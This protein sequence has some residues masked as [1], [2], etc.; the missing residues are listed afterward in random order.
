VELERERTIFDEYLRTPAGARASSDGLDSEVRVEA[1]EIV[2]IARYDH[3]AFALRDDR[4]GRVDD[5][6]C[7]GAPAE[8]ARGFCEDLVEWGNLRRSSLEQSTERNLAAWVAND[9]TD[10]AGWHNEPR[11][12]PERL[13]A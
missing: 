10:N 6:G 11:S 12:S 7:S 5:V 2:G 9:L 4:D 1:P 3:S 13:A 8:N